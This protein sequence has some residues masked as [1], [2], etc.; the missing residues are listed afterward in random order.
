[1]ESSLLGGQNGEFEQALGVKPV[2]KFNNI[3]L[4]GWVVN[5]FYSQNVLCEFERVC[6]QEGSE[7]AKARD[8]SSR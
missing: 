1:M 4:E 3:S 8:V 2:N 5:P 6:G 7:G